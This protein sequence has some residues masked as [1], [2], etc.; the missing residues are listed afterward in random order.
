MREIETVHCETQNVPL[1]DEAQAQQKEI[2]RT[3]QRMEQLG[4]Q[5]DALRKAGTRD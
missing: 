2:E 5:L 4:R 1:L 3:K